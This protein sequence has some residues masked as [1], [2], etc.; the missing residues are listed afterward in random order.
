MPESIDQTF[1]AKIEAAC[2][3]AAARVVR[4]ARQTDTPIIIW[5]HERGQVRAI[6]PDEAQEQLSGNPP[7]V[8]LDTSAVSANE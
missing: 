3:R 4:L 6:S 2:R 1:T 7:P 8:T 5:D